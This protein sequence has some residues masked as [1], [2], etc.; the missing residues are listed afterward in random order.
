MRNGS[1]ATL[2]LE[3][4]PLELDWFK[5]ERLTRA[6]YTLINRASLGVAHS[7]SSAHFST[8]YRL[9]ASQNPVATGQ[10]AQRAV[11]PLLDTLQDV[12]ADFRVCVLCWCNWRLP[13]WWHFIHAAATTNASK[14]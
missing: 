11:L 12:T 2:A 7:A 3:G 14:F 1:P 6:P 13:V 10:V 9:Y 5:V 8:L 4:S